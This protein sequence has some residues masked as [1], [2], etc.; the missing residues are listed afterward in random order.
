VAACGGNAW[1]TEESLDI[2]AVHNM[3]PDANVV[4]ASAASC[5]DAD[6]TDTIARIVD[7][8]LAN[9]VS[10][11]WTLGAADTNTPADRAAFDQVAQ[12][13]AAE[14]I[15]LYISTGDCGANDPATP[16]GAG[17]DKPQ[18]SYPAESPWVTAVGGSGGGTSFNYAEP[19]YQQGVVPSAVATGLPDGT[20][21]ASPMRVTPDVSADADN[22]TGMLVGQTVTLLD[23]SAHFEQTRFGGTS[24]STP[25]FAGLQALAEQARGT[26]IGFANPQLYARSGTAA[27]QDVTDAPFGQGTGFGVVRNDFTNPQDPTSAV[28]TRLDVMG[29]DGLLH[30]AVGFDEETGLGAP[31]ASAYLSSYQS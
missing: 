4:Y 16:C 21:A 14:G 3:A 20:T 26:P 9:I 12:Q 28:A 11:S 22:D 17:N 6:L 29:H 19:Q 13:A 24:L 15:G 10:A 18:P 27:I 25:L 23:G 1:F 5:S 30:G 8:H 31:A 2:D 7:N